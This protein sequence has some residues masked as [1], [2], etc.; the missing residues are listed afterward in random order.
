MPTLRRSELLKLASLAAA[1]GLVSPA[2]AADFPTR[3]VELVVPAS[4]GGGTDS[5]ARAFAD[6]VRRHSPHPFVVLNRPGA[7]G[8][9]GMGEVLNARP[10]GYK[11]SVVI[12][13]L[14]ILPYLNQIR[15]SPDDFRMIARLNADPASIVVRAEA[16]WKTLEEFL[17]DARKRPGEMTV[18][19]SGVGSIWHLSAAA[20]AEK[21]GVSFLHVPFAGAAPGIVSLLG[22][23]LQAMCTSPAEVSAH[24]QGGKLRLL[25]IMSDSRLAPYDSVP[26][27]K[28]LGHDLSLGTWRGFGVPKATPDAVVQALAAITRATVAE[29]G[30][31]EAMGRANLGFAFAEAG[32]FD[33]A[34]A[35][36]RALFK[37]LIER[38][39]LA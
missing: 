19:D 4:A 29:P 34:I 1:S 13:E 20:M 32:E 14:A 17:A 24:V 37:P 35:R 15:F 38:L 2:R 33:A 39:R 9:V 11:V 12:A 31:R 25:T 36:D 18:G 7:S 23:H 27:L 3:P 21:A 16:P 10:D 30:F 6:N 5:L 28:E 8:A 22:G 26:T